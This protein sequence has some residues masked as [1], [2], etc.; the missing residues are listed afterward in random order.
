V[1]ARRLFVCA[2]PGL[3]VPRART[4]R[5]LTVAVTVGAVAVGLAAQPAAASKLSRNST[6]RACVDKGNV[7]CDSA[8]RIGTFASGTVV[9]MRCW[10][11]GREET[12]A[13][14]SVR[15]FLVR[16]SSDSFEGFIHSS[17]IPKTQQ[18]AVGWCGNSLR[19]KAGMQAM[20]RMGQACASPA[21]TALFTAADWGVFCDPK[22][23][24]QGEWS[25]D[26][27]KLVWVAYKRAGYTL[28]DGDAAPTFNYYWKQ[29]AAKGNG[30]SY[31]R[32]GALV[33]YSYPAPFGHIA[34][35]VGGKSMA[36]TRGVDTNK[37]PNEVRSTSSV[38][39]YLGWVNPGYS[40][41]P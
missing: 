21:D 1:N 36:S 3:A 27:K 17:N 24:T 7:Y 34:V 38:P 25:G 8:H 20:R 2:L 16:R 41:V 13:Y 22:Q 19:V 33:G 28:V 18:T 32:Y 26:C 39:N 15:W 14:K 37:L 9:S 40:S 11:D 23:Q 10:Y 35:A 6:V 30:T 29:T 4:C 5:D 12:G 31:P